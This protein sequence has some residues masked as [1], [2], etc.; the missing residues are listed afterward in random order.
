MLTVNSS[1]LSPTRQPQSNIYDIENDIENDFYSSDTDNGVPFSPT[2][3]EV[4]KEVSYNRFNKAPVHQFQLESNKTSTSVQQ[5]FEQNE[6]KKTFMQQRKRKKDTETKVPEP[7]LSYKRK[8]N[9]LDNF[10]NVSST[11]IEKVMSR[12]DNMLTQKSVMQD[13]VSVD[14]EIS[15]MS[16]YISMSLKKIKTEKQLP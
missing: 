6:D 7:D 2:A 13:S 5:K 14:K 12:V 10:L 1:I 15:T 8:K 11:N 3:K 16:E 4:L 9:E